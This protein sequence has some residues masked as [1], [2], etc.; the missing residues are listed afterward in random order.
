[1]I[2]AGVISQRGLQVRDAVRAEFFLGYVSQVR[3]YSV[4]ALILLIILVRERLACV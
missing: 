1:M 4:P 3:T 2:A